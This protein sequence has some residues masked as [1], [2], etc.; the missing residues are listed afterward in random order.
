[1]ELTGLIW[2]F[3]LRKKQ[4]RRKH[5]MKNSVLLRLLFSI[6]VAAFSISASGRAS[7]HHGPDI[8]FGKQQQLKGSVKYNAKT[9]RL[10]KLNVRFQE[11]LSN[12]KYKSYTF[13]KKAILDSILI[14][15]S[16]R[17][18]DSLVK[19]DSYYLSGMYYL[20]SRVYDDALVMLNESYKI[21]DLINV[22]DERTA[23][24]LYNLGLIYIAF[25]D[26]YT[27][28]ELN[29]K[30]IDLYKSIMGNSNIILVDPYSALASAY[31]ELQ[32]TEKALSISNDALSI[33]KAHSDSISP[34]RL[35]DLYSNLG[36][37][38]SRLADYS[39][40]RIYFE[41]SESIQSRNQPDNTQSYINLINSLAITYDALGLNDKSEDYYQKGVALALASSE[42]SSITLNIVNSYAI[43]LANSENFKKSEELYKLLL[44]KATKKKESEPQI[45]FEV[46]ND[47]ADFLREYVKN[48]SLSIEYNEMCMNYLEKNPNDLI[49]RNRVYVSYALSLLKGGE[50]EKALTTIQDLIILQ[51]NLDSDFEL[52]SNPDINLIKP[53]KIS[54]KIFRTKY[55]ILLDNFRKTNNVEILKT[56]ARTSE[57]VI[58]LLEK[59]RIN[60]SEEESKLLLGDKYREL[61]FNAIRDFN[62][63]FKLTGD[64]KYL[65]KAF[66]YS[67]KSKVAGLLASTRELKAA[68]FQ[69][70]AELGQLEFRL[71]REL[72]TL[73]AMISE[74]TNK[75][76]LNQM[77][78]NSLN[79]KILE[80]T[81]VRDSLISEFS[82]HYPAYYSVK[83]N[84]EVADIES[85][86][87][88]V[89]RN[90]NYLNYVLSDTVLYIFVANRKNNNLISISVDSSF[91]DKVKQF[92]SLLLKPSPSEDAT[93]AFISFQKTGYGLYKIL[94]EPIRPFLISDQLVISPDN[95]LSYIPF[96]ALP[97][98][99]EHLTNRQ[100]RALHYLHEDFDISYT[101]SATYLA[102]SDIHNLKISNKSVSFAPS[103]TDTI[104]I[105]SVLMSRQ[106]E[107]RVLRDLP[108][109]RQ[110]A[111][112]VS[113]ITNGMLYE[114]TDAKES[115]FKNVSGNY[116]I[117]HLAMHT[118]LND[119]DP[120]RSTLIFSPESDTLNDGHLRTFEVY[121]IP[122]KAKMVV[123][124]SCNTGSGFLSTGEGILSL[125][126]GFIYSG[127]QSVV[128]SMWEIEDRSGTE[129]VKLFYDNLK[130]GYSKSVALR[131]ARITYLKKSDMLR[132][133][134]YYWSTLV[135]YGDN[136][137][138]Y[139]N[140]YL[141]TAL[142]AIVLVLTVLTVLY[143]RKRRYS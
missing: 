31:I 142:A 27:V 26:F 46:L 73:N 120:M 40:A 124:S 86:P 111:E 10:N 136:S 55:N 52:F 39:N 112:Y 74:E 64:S 22:K 12:P 80:T 70:P 101:Y 89:G 45:Y 87:D 67:E 66:E 104:N 106:A 81:R 130:K 7:S 79:E 35:S 60:I 83:Y 71:K 100:Y 134:P 1:M 118:L 30:A 15:V 129:I 98:K 18:I 85:V 76:I 56:A 36:V 51:Y 135:V 62:D 141:L 72:G 38:Y 115:V 117:I 108:Y 49:L 33:A 113:G 53:D 8:T 11:L 131:K 63:L 107:D 14:E 42:N 3:I 20:F 6:A 37:C 82:R 78:I 84:T 116:G 24:I 143:L 2:I 105:K 59:M 132:S 19:S 90:G 29:I 58:S 138:I 133:H 77:L 9:I 125:A 75:K 17:S 54:L 128:M 21:R 93:S 95:M 110:E 114:N 44:E 92:R 69:I 91:L 122:L 123:L 5:L 65:S 32:E 57:L 50:Y 140:R 25:G 47:Y 127:S 43:N 137:P 102:E 61:Y 16:D 103:Y 68:Q 4:G 96:T 99:D 13:T 48:F 119:K 23:R 28:K 94:I 34:Q 41:I 109:A 139:C 121:G 88:I 126:R 97:V